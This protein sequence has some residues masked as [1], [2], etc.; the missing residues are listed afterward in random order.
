MG[1]S[2]ALVQKL[3]HPDPKANSRTDWERKAASVWNLVQSTPY[4]TGDWGGSAS[5]LFPGDVNHFP[6]KWRDLLSGTSSTSMDPGSTRTRTLT[7]TRGLN[8]V[9]QGQALEQCDKGQSL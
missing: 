1:A 7:R 6:R 2:S 8:P 5:S 9:L 3:A 4:D